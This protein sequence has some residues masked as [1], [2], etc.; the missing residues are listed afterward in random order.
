MSEQEHLEYLEY[1]RA[2]D[3]EDERRHQQDIDDARAL[4]NS[5][6]YVVVKWS[7]GASWAVGEIRDIDGN[8]LAIELSGD[9][10]R[11][12]ANQINQIWSDANFDEAE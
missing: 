4:L 3:H 12:A 11:S 7:V 10:S 6:G 2:K 8:G 9:E 5:E 1:Q